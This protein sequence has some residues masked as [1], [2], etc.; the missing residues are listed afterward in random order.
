MTIEERVQGLSLEDLAGQVLCYEVYDHDDPARIEN[1]FK[2]MRPGGVF[3]SKMPV[4]KIKMYA[5]MANKYAKI[6]VIISSD[7]ETGP[8]CMIE[9]TGRLPYPMSW[10]A[11]DSP[12]LVEEAGRLTGAICRKNGIHWTYAPVVDINYNFQNPESNIRSVSE[13]PKQVVKIMKAYMKGLQTN[14]YV[15]ATIKHFPGQG[16]DVR[17]SHFCTTINNQTKEEWM[18]T[19]GYVYKEMIKAGA[20]SIMI[21]HG[22][23]P[24]YEEENDPFFGPPPAV[25]SKSMMTDLLKGE[26][27]FDGCLVSDAMSMIGVASRVDN[28]ED[29]AVK[30]LLAG[31]DMILFPEPNDYANIIAAVKSGKLPLERLKDAV[32]RILRLKESV[33]LFEDQ[34]KVNEE[35]GE[36]GTVD[37]VAQAIA[38]KAI[39][40]VRN[41]KEV[42][43]VQMP[44]GSRVLMLNMFEPHFHK[45]A[46][47]NEFEPMRKAFEERGYIVD[48]IHT[49]QY[50]EVQKIMDNYELI[51][52]NCKMGPAD[53]HGAS[54]RLGWNNIMVL[55]RGY[56]L[57]HKRVVFTSFGDP[58]K[59]FDMPYLKEYI[60][61]FSNDAATQRAVV[62]V[63]LGEIE[64][65]G[66]NPVSLEGFFQR[67]V[68]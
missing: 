25:L 7:V 20:P 19:Y 27:G 2:N 47:G 28:M 39:K 51:C 53:Y 65:Q 43:P 34:E 44:K 11:S 26:L 62:K 1:V 37:E 67:E 4:E 54:M 58:Y 17:N 57:H 18:E 24:C 46:T 14:G 68:E 52:L 49:A 23:L 45:P 6:P 31:G 32:I 40:V 21:G 16:M 22:A 64:P 42:L 33:R 29:V 63:I 66:K 3:L 41:V 35:I 61:A 59:L 30:Y 50:D 55:W 10:G 12:E 9:G 36:T 13:S 8:E 38:D 15:A 5:D 56:V 60:N 48:E